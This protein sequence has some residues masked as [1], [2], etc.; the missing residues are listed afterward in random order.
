MFKSV[1]VIGMIVAALSHGLSS[2]AAAAGPKVVIGYGAVNARVAP[3]WIAQEQK[4]FTKNGVDA[5]TILV[6]QIQVTIGGISTGEIQIG[7]T[8]GSTLLGAAAGGL[9][10]E[11]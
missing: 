11:K 9:D 3:L 10:L 2:H 6:G 7:H 1:A 8:S 5:E 4:L